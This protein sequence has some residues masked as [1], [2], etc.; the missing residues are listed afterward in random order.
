MRIGIPGP[1]DCSHSKDKFDAANAYRCPSEV[2]TKT[3]SPRCRAG[4][5]SS[6]GSDQTAIEVTLPT[7]D[8]VV[9]SGPPGKGAS[10][11]N[12][13]ALSF[14]AHKVPSDVPRYPTRSRYAGF[15]L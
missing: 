12:S 5:G 13:T 9:T 15:V 8:R 7:T 6:V 2:P 4:A 10:P 3:D 14:N 1:N 11:S